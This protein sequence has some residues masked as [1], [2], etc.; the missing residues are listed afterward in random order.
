MINYKYLESVSLSP[1][2]SPLQAAG[3]GVHAQVFGDH[4]TMR[5]QGSLGNTRWTWGPYQRWSRHPDET[6]EYFYSNWI[7]RKIPRSRLQRSGSKTVYGLCSAH[8]TFRLASVCIHILLPL[9]VQLF[10]YY[11][12]IGTH[13]TFI[14]T[15]FA[16]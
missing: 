8:P 9:I 6:R 11:S 5:A 13:L 4:G 16:H 14:L 1:V 15:Q 12:L 3:F 2:E 7:P 10:P